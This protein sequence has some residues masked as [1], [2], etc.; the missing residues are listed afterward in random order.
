MDTYLQPL[1]EEFKSLWNGVA[2]HDISRP[3]QER[4]FK[5]HGI[6]GWT[7]HDYP[8]LGVCSSKLF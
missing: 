1:I 3:I 4:N 8:G 7:M 2:M 5:F 6:L